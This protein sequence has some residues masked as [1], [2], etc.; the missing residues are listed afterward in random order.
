M[1]LDGID[2]TTDE[3]GDVLGMVYRPSQRIPR[4]T[5][6]RWRKTMQAQ[7]NVE[8]ALGKLQELFAAGRINTRIYQ[9]LVEAIKREA[10]QSDPG[11]G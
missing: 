4:A 7:Q 3:A 9:G 1:L 6:R 8:E 5:F 11:D 10:L 2:P